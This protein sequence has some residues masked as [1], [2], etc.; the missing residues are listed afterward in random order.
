MGLISEEGLFNLA[1]AMVSVHQ[2]ELECIN[3]KLKNNT[4]EVMQPR[5]KSKSNL[6]AGE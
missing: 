4:L 3:E 1:K 5:I 6:P 2:K